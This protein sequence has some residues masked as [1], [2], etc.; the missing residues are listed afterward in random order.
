MAGHAPEPASEPTNRTL[1]TIVGAI[2]AALCLTFLGISAAV[3]ASGDD[4]HG[5]DHTEE[6][7]H[8]DDKGDEE[9]HSDEG[10]DHDGDDSEDNS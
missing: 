4:D 7:D 10:G 8:S 3:A 2:F 5:S 1:G 9:D 6:G